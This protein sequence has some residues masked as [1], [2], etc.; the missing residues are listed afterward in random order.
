MPGLRRLT[1][2]ACGLV[3]SLAGCSDNFLVPTSGP[4][5]EADVIPS[6]PSVTAAPPSPALVS[7]RYSDGL[8]MTIDGEHAWRPTDILS[9]ATLPSGE[10]LVSAWDLGGMAHSCPGQFPGNSSF[11]CPDFEALA[12]VRGGP[13]VITLAWQDVPIQEAA[14]L[15]VRVTVR[16]PEPCLSNPPGSCPGPSLDAIEVVWAGNPK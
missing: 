6:T 15:V 9:A 10:L 2:V 14:A 7:A 5:N 4:S 16:A 8:P 13:Y 12:D 11:Q 1:L 3:A